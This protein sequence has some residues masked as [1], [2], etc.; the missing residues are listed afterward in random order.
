MPSAVLLLASEIV[1][2][3]VGSLFSDTLK[4]AVPPASVV[5]PVVV[6]T[7]TPAVSLSVMFAPTLATAIP[8]YIGSPTLAAVCVTRPGC[9]LTL[10]LPS[11]SI[12][13][14]TAVTVTIWGT[15][16]PP[17]TEV[18]GVKVRTWVTPP[19]TVSCT[20]ALAEIVTLPSGW[21]LRA[22]V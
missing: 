1:T 11:S 22:I 12:A 6:E 15:F 20:S 13:S 4:V 3:A 7:F 19:P 16:Q 9:V 5:V 2:S 14:S 17:G 18:F 8:L 21:L 10:L